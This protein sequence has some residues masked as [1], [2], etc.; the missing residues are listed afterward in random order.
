MARRGNSR[1]ERAPKR[2]PVRAI[3]GSELCLQCGLCCD[4]TVFH[5]GRLDDG[6]QDFV[7]SLGL[8][9]EPKPG[10]GHALSLP[11]PAFL[12]GCCSRYTEPRPAICGDYRCGLLNEYVAG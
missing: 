9:V 6:E 2:I 11:C 10:G 12:D 4:G 1:P 7:E 3:D 8:P 5:H